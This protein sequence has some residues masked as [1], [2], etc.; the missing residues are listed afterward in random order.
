MAF[1]LPPAAVSRSAPRAAAQCGPP[2]RARRRISRRAVLSLAVSAAAGAGVLAR[3][4]QALAAGLAP[5]EAR[6][7]A[8]AAR[9]VT[10]ELRDLA[11]LEQWSAFRAALRAGPMS[12]VRASCSALARA[13]T[14]DARRARAQDAYKRLVR[15]VERADFAALQ[16]ERGKTT[17]TPVDALVDA[18]ESEFDAFLETV[19]DD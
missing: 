5:S 7:E 15:E 17:T 2:P 12:R 11:Q 8:G 9:A 1:L 19:R 14:D 4:A 13:Q 3:G 10:G 16:R 6:A 18:V